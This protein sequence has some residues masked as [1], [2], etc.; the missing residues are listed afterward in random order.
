MWPEAAEVS[1]PGFEGRRR[2]GECA[3]AFEVRSE[4]MQEGER[5]QCP[6]AGGKATE[7]GR[8]VRPEGQK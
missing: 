3:I 1:R 8:C 7:K 5:N 2:S 4:W 6:W